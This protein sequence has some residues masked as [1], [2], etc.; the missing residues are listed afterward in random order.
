MVSTTKRRIEYS[1]GDLVLLS[2]LSSKPISSLDL[3]DQFYKLRPPKPMNAR[4][5][6]RSMMKSLIENLDH[7]SDPHKVIA[8]RSAPKPMEYRK[9]KR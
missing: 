1:D 3:A 2:L 7:N 4:Q 5:S 6:I 9:V 8:V